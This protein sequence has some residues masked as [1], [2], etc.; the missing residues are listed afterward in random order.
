MLGN[1]GIHNRL[2]SLADFT[3]A[4]DEMQFCRLR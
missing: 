3:A 2:V 4:H 1:K